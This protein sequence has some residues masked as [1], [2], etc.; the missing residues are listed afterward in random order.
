MSA[1]DRPGRRSH[2]TARSALNHSLNQSAAQSVT[3]VTARAPHLYLITSHII[4]P[5][6]RPPSFLL[7]LHPSR[8]ATDRAGPR[9]SG[10]RQCMCDLPLRPILEHRVVRCKSCRHHYR[11]ARCRCDE[12]ARAGEF[13]HLVD[14]VGACV[15]AFRL[16]AP[17]ALVRARAPRRRASTGLYRV[18]HRTSALPIA[19]SSHERG[20][21]VCALVRLHGLLVEII[22]VLVPG[23]TR[24]A[25]RC[26]ACNARR[27]LTHHGCRHRGALSHRRA[28]GL[29]SGR[30]CC[31]RVRRDRRAKG[32]GHWHRSKG[33][34]GR[35]R[36]MQKDGR[37]RDRLLAHIGSTEARGDVP[38]GH[39]R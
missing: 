18:A 37:H 13:A 25:A 23:H 17:P 6:A 12:R 33:H 4:S 24:G 26:T 32:R 30:T 38:R 28:H 11:R 10:H 3:Y 29:H 5:S 20:G 7:P 39:R 19:H 34:A 16:P 27:R 15:P 14:C 8:A 36:R 22:I 1:T 21:L 35:R 2:D 9:S 31:V